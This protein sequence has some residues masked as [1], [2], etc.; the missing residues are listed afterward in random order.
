MAAPLLS[1]YG[2]EASFGAS[3]ETTFATFVAPTVFHAIEDCSPTPS[4]QLI[5]RTGARKRRGQSLPL[6]D[7]Y[8]GK[9]TLTPEC[10]PDTVGQ[11]IAFALG[12]QTAPSHTV[13]GSSTST[14]AYT[15]TLKL[16]QLPSFSAELN[17]ITDAIDYLGCRVNGMTLDF[18]PGK[19][20]TPTFDIVYAT[21]D[22]QGSPTSP[23]FSTK[24]PF[25]FNNPLHV[26]TLFGSAAGAAGDVT[27]HQFSVAL[28]N[29]LVTNYYSAGSGTRSVVDFPQQAA[30]VTGKAKLGFET[31]TAYQKFLGAA[32]SPGNVVAGVAFDFNL[33]TTDEIDATLAIY[34]GIEI[35]VGNAIIQT[36]SAPIKSGGIIYQD[37]SF[38]AG[39]TG[40]G[41][42]DDLLINLTNTASAIY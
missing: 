1:P 27:V 17:R 42:N 3:K 30:N 8:V 19:G 5:K 28:K 4:N 39:E 18:S 2:E 7:G 6:A 23:T 16:G 31:D 37:I 34:Y 11:L 24:V 20:L 25:I 9:M 12:A 13:K 10:D 35:V 38:E 40:N 14:T 21:E 26:V 36:H 32:T 29:N 15:S 22:V 41:N 33:V